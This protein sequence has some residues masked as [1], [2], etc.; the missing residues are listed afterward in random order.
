MTDYSPT[1][2][3]TAVLDVADTPG[4]AGSAA[5]TVPVVPEEE[6]SAGQFTFV[7]HKGEGSTAQESVVQEGEGS[8]AHQQSL[9]QEGEG[10][11][12]HQESLVQ[13]GEGS[14]AHQQ[15]LVQ[16]G[17]GSAAHQQSLVQEGEG[18]AAHQESL[19]QEGEG[20][21]VHQESLV[22]EGE[23]SA[24]HQQ[25][26]VQ[27]EDVEM[28][29]GVVQTALVPVERRSVPQTIPTG[30][31]E[32]YDLDGG[33]GWC[34]VVSGFITLFILTGISLSLA[35]LLGAYMAELKAPE[36]LGIWIFNVQSAVW[37]FAGASENKGR[38]EELVELGARGTGAVLEERRV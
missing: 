8:A 31:E 2:K 15:S 20:S 29:R 36:S 23:G 4:M 22:Q 37:C 28:R 35:T 6:G 5:Q 21:A 24:A 30:F 25:S 38:R 1:E 10:S 26:L 32:E 16:E 3:D 11:A 27:E 7:V 34:I 18:S 14:A 17:E 9:V 12:G 33:W 19:V 13:E